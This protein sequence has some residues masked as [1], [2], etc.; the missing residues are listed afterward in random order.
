MTD[1]VGIQDAINEVLTT[2]TGLCSSFIV[3]I[4]LFWARSAP[5]SSPSLSIPISLIGAVFLML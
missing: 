3:V 2:L 1:G 5:C 4:F